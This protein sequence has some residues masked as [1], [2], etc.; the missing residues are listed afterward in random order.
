MDWQT[1]FVLAGFTAWVVSTVTLVLVRLDARQ[2]R[3]DANAAEGHQAACSEIRNKILS[4]WEAHNDSMHQF[5]DSFFR[6]VRK[7]TS[8]HED[9]VRKLS[10]QIHADLRES[11]RRVLPAIP[12][13]G[14]EPVS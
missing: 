10:E 12:K 4:G 2:A 5:R 6:E 9:C 14:N 7:M 13:K 1:V 3:L 8:D 11:G